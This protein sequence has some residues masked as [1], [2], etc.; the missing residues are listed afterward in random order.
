M[1]AAY[2]GWGANQIEDA[3]RLWRRIWLVT[4]GT[5]AS[6]QRLCQASRLDICLRVGGE[7]PCKCHHW[8]NIPH[9]KRAM[10]IAI[11][12]GMPYGLVALQVDHMP[13]EVASQVDIYI[14][15]CETLP[16]LK[17]QA[18]RVTALVP[19]WSSR[20]RGELSEGKIHADCL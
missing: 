6:S 11:R 19:M 9:R 18:E 20:I 13:H 16:S 5:L 10:L 7:M 4:G 3:R 8:F 15:L 1:R 12:A 2:L 17:A 14:R